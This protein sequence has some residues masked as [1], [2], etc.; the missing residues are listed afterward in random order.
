[1][2]KT[3]H[4]IVT[5]TMRACL[6]TVALTAFIAQPVAMACTWTGSAQGCG[7]G[8]GR[9]GFML[10]HA[11]PPSIDICSYTESVGYVTT[12]VSGAPPMWGWNGCVPNGTASCVYTRTYAY[13]CGY[14]S[15]PI[16]ETES[17]PVNRPDYLA[18]GG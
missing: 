17:V 11:E 9:F 12:C 3:I 5:K 2:K 13:C 15:V 16:V 1:M 4:N 6:V 7:G 10:C 14:V 18:C 8:S